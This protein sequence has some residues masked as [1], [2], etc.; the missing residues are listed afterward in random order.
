M[1]PPHPTDWSTIARLAR[2]GIRPGESFDFDALDPSLQAALKD[3]PAAARELMQATL[4]GIAKIVNGWQMNTDTMGVYGNFYLKRALVAKLG[5]GA[6]QPEDAIYPLCLADADGRPLN[7]DN[8][9]ILHFEQDEIPPVGAF[10][11]VTMYDGEGFAAANPINR[12]AIGDRDDLTFN[13]DGSLDLYIQHDNPGTAHESN[14]LPAPRGPLGVTMRLYAPAPQA[15]DG[16]WAPPA[17]K[18]LQ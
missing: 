18:R 3:A 5:L 12:L 17:T 4:P 16:R 14:W 2:I 13:G 9:Y 15:L 7:G 1:H 6:N 10:W 11:S 8:D